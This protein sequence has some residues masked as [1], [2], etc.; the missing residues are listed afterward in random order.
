MKKASTHKI[1]SKLRKLT[2]YSTV[3][4]NDTCR[5]STF[6]MISRFFKIQAHLNVLVELL[7]FLPTHLEIGILFNA[8]LSLTKIDRITVL[9][10]R[11][12]ITFVEVRDNFKIVLKD[13][14]GFA[15]HLG[16]SA[17][18][19]ENPDFG[20]LLS[21]SLLVCNS[22]MSSNRQHPINLPLRI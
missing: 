5:S 18:I 4:D 15:H 1:T 12:G 8:H 20:K 17:S 19:V 3:R 10:Q 16:H 21:K 14:P 11:D 6:Q 2:A 9:L 13:Y 7:E 22:Q